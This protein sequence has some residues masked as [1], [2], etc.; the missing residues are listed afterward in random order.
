MAK[1]IYKMENILGIKYK[2][3]DQAKT[4]YGMARMK[5]TEEEEKL[6][7]LKQKVII[8]QERKKMIM[9]TKLDIIE[10]RQCE[11]AIE[12]TKYF[13]KQQE[14][15]VK[16]AEQHLELM[17]TRLNTAMVERKTHEKLKDNALQEFF[18]EYE[19]GE[20]KEI[21]ELVSFK[22]NNPTDY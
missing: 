2:M 13:I 10:L 21:D 3:E 17:R 20:R 4:A 8:Y 11:E 15:A 1:F 16:K 19:S 6:F 9:S 7:T 18:V 22:Y 12:I 14:I 5:L